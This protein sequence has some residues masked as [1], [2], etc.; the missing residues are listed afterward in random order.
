MF[1]NNDFENF[2][3]ELFREIKSWEVYLSIRSFQMWYKVKKLSQSFSK[4]VNRIIFRFI[5]RLA[6]QVIYNA[7]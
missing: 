1:V 5:G 3:K 4:Y 6:P 2:K 7:G